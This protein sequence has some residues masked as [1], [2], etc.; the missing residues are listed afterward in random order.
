V[1]KSN[2]VKEFSESNNRIEI[3]E[4]VPAL[5]Y[6]LEVEPLIYPANANITIITRLINNRETPLPLT[7]DLSLTNDETGNIIVQR[8]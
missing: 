4:E 7:L 3:T 6:S 5:F 2:A 1:D 8:N